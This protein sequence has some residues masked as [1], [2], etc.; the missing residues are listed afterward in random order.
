MVAD[1]VVGWAMVIGSALSASVGCAFYVLR[2][3]S[4]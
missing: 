1:L 2:S 4:K 3:W